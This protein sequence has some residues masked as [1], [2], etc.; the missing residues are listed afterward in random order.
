MFRRECNVLINACG[1]L[2]NWKWPSIPGL[3]DFK[4]H[5]TH[6]AQWDW[7][8]DFKDKKIAVIGAGSSAIQIIPELRPGN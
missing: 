6:S 1:V 8:Y 3:H 5:L 2:N 4:G 7:N